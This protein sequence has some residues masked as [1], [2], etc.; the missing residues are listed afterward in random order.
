M[1]SFDFDN[2]FDLNGCIAGKGCHTDRGASVFSDQFSK[3]FH[4]EIREAIDHL[5]LFTKS[6]CGIDHTE[7]F[8]DTFDPIEAT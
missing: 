5:R 8:Y 2:H 6:I 3:D 7:D 4:H 1:G